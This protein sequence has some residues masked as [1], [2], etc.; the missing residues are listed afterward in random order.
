M[1]V[2]LYKSHFNTFRN[3]CKVLTLH[4]MSQ[5]IFSKIIIH[6]FTTHHDKIQ[7]I[8]CQKVYKIFTCSRKPISCFSNHKSNL[9]QSRQHFC[10]LWH[11]AF[12]LMLNK[13]PKHFLYSRK[14]SIRNRNP[15]NNIFKTVNICLSNKASHCM[16][17]LKNLLAHLTT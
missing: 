14:F 7:D 6:I 3:S 8:S 12:H 9:C 4:A 1:L 2:Y 16:P 15:E 10:L 5:T 17:C 11:K 13:N